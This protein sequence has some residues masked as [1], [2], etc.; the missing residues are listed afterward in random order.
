MSMVGD[1]RVGITGNVGDNKSVAGGTK[2]S[3][4]DQL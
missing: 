2:W 4:V 3:S 1:I